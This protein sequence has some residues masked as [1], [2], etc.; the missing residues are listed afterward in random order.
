M[1]PQ[2]RAI[3]NASVVFGNGRTLPFT[4]CKKG[5]V[6]CARDGRRY[7]CP[8]HDKLRR[9]RVQSEGV[10]RGELDV[11]VFWA[12]HEHKHT[13]ADQPVL[14]TGKLEGFAALAAGEDTGGPVGKAF[15]PG[16]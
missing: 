13:V 3:Q 11:S 14:Q 10:R 16:K 4:P 1:T 12:L 7:A 6:P 5:F 8:L 9:Q 2:G 15:E